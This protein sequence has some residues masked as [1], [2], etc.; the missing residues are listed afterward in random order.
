MRTNWLRHNTTR[1]GAMTLCA[2]LAASVVTVLATQVDGYATTQVD[3]SAPLVWVTSDSQL[4]VG[5]VNK[6]I[7]ELDAAVLISDS[8]DV[9]QEK[10]TVLVTDR[11]ERVI[12]PIDVSTA[13]AGSRI[14]M[15]ASGDAVLGGDIL[16]VSDAATGAIWAGAPLSLAGL[17]P[18]L[19]PPAVVTGASVAMTVSRLGTVFAVVPGGSDL[20]T[21]PL[22]S[23]TAPAASASPASSTA[24]S[25]ATAPPSTAGAGSGGS[26][27]SAAPEPTTLP[28]E[29]LGTEKVG[30]LSALD[31]TAVGD[32]P[33]VLDRD[34][35]RLLVGGHEIPVPG[36]QGAVLQQPGPAADDVLVATGTA[37]LRV[38]LSGGD[39]VTVTDAVSGE[40]AAPVWL[41]GCA[42]AAWAGTASTYV[43]ACGTDAA[44]LTPIG[45]S[46]G[47]KSLVFRVNRDVV[48]I[49][50]RATGQIWSIDPEGLTLIDNW[51]SVKDLEQPEEDS[52]ENGEN[53]STEDP[54][55]EATECKG[56]APEKPVAVKDAF[57][58]RMGRS[59]LLGV[60]DNDTLS[61][62]ST[63]VIASFDEIDP[64]VGSLAVVENGRSLQLTL[65]DGAPPGPVTFAYTVSDGLSEPV[66]AP[67]TV[68]PVGRDEES[69]TPKLLRKSLV[70]VEVG[71]SATYNV[72]DDWISPTGDDLYLAKATPAPGS[73]D[74]VTFLP[75]GAVTFNDKGSAAVKKEVSLTVTDASGSAISGKLVVEV[76][77]A[78]TAKVM[79]KPVYSEALTG[80]PVT[81]RLT[82]AVISPGVDPVRLTK[83]AATK[84]NGAISLQ[85][86]TSA[87]S[88]T[89]TSTKAGTYYFA[90]SV[91]AGKADAIG[92]LRVEVTD[93]P[94]KP[95]RPVAVADVVYLP[96]GGIVRMDPT[97]NDRDPNGGG[98]AVQRLDRAA[99]TGLT[100]ASVEMHLLTISARGSLPKGTATLPYVVSNGVGTATG[101]IR[102]ISVPAVKAPPPAASPI[103]V[104]VRAGDAVTIPIVDHAA[105]PNGDQLV[106]TV[107]STKLA[108]D[109][110]ILFATDTA[111][112]YLAPAVPPAKAVRFSYTVVNSTQG[113][114]V[115]TAEVTVVPAD[116]PNEAPRTPVTTVARAFT[117]SAVTVGLPLDGI[118][119]NGDWVTLDG[120][121][122]AGLKK[123]TVLSFG[124]RTVNYKSYSTGGVDSFTYSVSDPAPW[125]ESV[126][127][128]AKVV[129]IDR[130]TTVDPPVAPE[131]EVTTR[132]GRAIG[133]DVLSGV[134]DS[135]GE[136]E[137]VADSVVAPDGWVASVKDGLLI[138]EPPEVPA[139]GAIKYQVVN[140]RKLTGTGVVT[141]EV[142]EDAAIAPPT[143]TDYVVTQAEFDSVSSVATVDV[144]SKISNPGGLPQ[145][146][147]LALDDRA[148]GE[149]TLTDARTISVPVTDLRQVLAYR[150]SD[151]TDPDHQEATAF[152][153][154]PPA[155]E[156]APA[157]D[158]IADQPQDRP[159]PVTPDTSVQPDRPKAPVAIEKNTVLEVN[160]GATVTRDI[161]EF[162]SLNEG[163]AP[164]IVDGIEM[165][166][167][168]GAVGRVNATSFQYT[169]PAD[170]TA[171][172]AI[173]VSVTSQGGT[174]AV[175]V[176]I[177]V[178]IIQ[179]D[180]PPVS[181]VGATLSVEAGKS[182]S[183]DLTGLVSSALPDPDFRF[184][185]GQAGSGFTSSLGPDNVLTVG[186]DLAM[187]VGASAGVSISVTDGPGRETA[188]ATVTVTVESS[189]APPLR[190]KTIVVG[191]ARPG[192]AS[193][194]DLQSAVTFNPF[195]SA[196]TVV[197]VL[198]PDA[199]TATVNWTSG[200]LVTITPSAEF[201]KGTFAVP[202]TLVDETGAAGRQVSGVIKVT[203][204]SRPD[205]PG[206]PSVVKGSVAS[207]TLD[208]SWT[209]PDGNGYRVDGY[210]VTSVRG[211]FTQ[212]C[213]GSPCTITG[214]ENGV[215]Y[216]FTVAA[217][218]QLDWSE[219]SAPSAEKTP[220]EVPN[221]PAP[222]VPG[223][224]PQSVDSLTVS[225]TPPKVDGSPIEKYLIEVS[226]SDTAAK[227]VDAGTRSL[228]WSGLT[229]G[230]EYRFRVTAISKAGSSTPSE[231]GSSEVPS[232][233]PDPPTVS[234]L[235]F[236][237]SAYTQRSLTVQWA[238]PADNGG[239]PITGYAVTVLADGA[240]LS[241]TSVGP[242]DTSSTFSVT[243]GVSYT[244]TVATVNVRGTSDP[245]SDGGGGVV[246]FTTP[247][248]VSPTVTTTAPN[249]AVIT[250]AG[251]AGSG[252]KVSYYVVSE[253][254][255]PVDQ[256][257]NSG[258]GQ[259]HSKELVDLGKGAHTYGISACYGEDATFNQC[260]PPAEVTANVFD[261]VGR[262]DVAHVDTSQE[263]VRFNWSVPGDNGRG[264]ITVERSVDGGGWADDNSGTIVI[265]NGCNQGH[266]I[267]VRARDAAGLYGEENSASGTTGACPPVEWVM[268]APAGAANDSCTQ[269]NFAASAFNDKVT[270]HTCSNPWVRGGSS[271]VVTCFLN[272]GSG[273][274]GNWYR[275][276]GA[277]ADGYYV[278]AS[279]V[280]GNID[281]M[282]HC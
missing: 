153:V 278:I 15:A 143:A 234:P 139:V 67:V 52:Q 227:T 226:P 68:T 147:E 55:I 93:K 109:Q 89:V 162:V 202:F 37:L 220:D 46:V 84:P 96:Q 2:V 156:I 175:P 173:S 275:I 188:T 26:D 237:E 78:G 47:S 74:E 261:Q 70:Q 260:G 168:A 11:K 36:G 214:L 277:P 273:W 120:V 194:V 259:A 253:N 112:R 135:T 206:A 222:P 264:P 51:E 54:T 210:R 199:G 90:Y 212:D 223:Y 229:Q 136:V 217:H 186:A 239:K 76:L 144:S 174:E 243:D 170:G 176:S 44:V 73:A 157:T 211:G 57:G 118:D 106:I 125:H 119:P 191:D 251:I 158:P 34:S 33:V 7:N 183:I 65:A 6:Q 81:V 61:D 27:P 75:N 231:F 10:D 249:R 92:Y 19:T 276:R 185:V 245:Q 111:I 40:P 197:E 252:R 32:V 82:A 3:L 94:D 148:A 267:R 246:P 193:T 101:Q 23:G 255:V 256:V 31:I 95:A 247:G 50:D 140:S 131:L 35:G 83:V 189:S 69:K 271:V 79:P 272:P 145:N 242:A 29:P 127:G 100:V 167:T 53:S 110:G 235:T 207:H 133:V 149:A 130:P 151:P 281:G 102:V 164:V 258:E 49:N 24:A 28:G 177:Q 165:T 45:G 141:V 113:K 80:E 98:L 99:A 241:Q 59:T 63:S 126:N 216:S 181:L 56:R 14:A 219:E 48:V 155:A 161:G 124:T 208:L 178:V 154:V 39:P 1:F 105:D 248:A 104:R 169:A 159:D 180:P 88:V 187:T 142:S 43:F 274:K 22:G 196:P 21:L 134:E 60:L 263:A 282:P 171:E 262:P 122:P 103:S 236:G 152:V 132:P 268:T 9:L 114:A 121:D 190:L 163:L 218:N 17:D 195:A 42:H 128:T 270:P 280:S 58:A 77:A 116:A 257:A 254:G 16:A 240:V 117:S 71:G 266:S 192:E 72:L 201:K 66:S 146:L 38:P 166:T 30:G 129:V 64:K 5:R 184:E 238:K 209:E 12:R 205:T 230:V 13:V 91:S 137:F 86:D 203:V 250:W 224:I 138:I 215:S 25:T 62:C 172:A 179:E 97:A 115:S 265:G 18:S 198:G 107:D 244:A 204:K 108:P 232:R 4:S 269:G 233:R 87:G 160:A 213:K 150:V 8:I 225:W 85:T 279:G 200:N 228:T 20:W 182:A 41:N 123:G 221:T